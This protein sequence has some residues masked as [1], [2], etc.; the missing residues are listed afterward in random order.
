MSIVVNEDLELEQLDVKTAFLHGD[1]EEEIYMSQPEGYEVEGKEHWVCLLRKSLYGLKQ[2]PRQWNQKFDQFMKEIGFQRSCHDQCVYIK[3]TTDGKIYLLLYVDDM[4]VAC[5]DKK[6]IQA[7]KDQ[8]NSR[9]EMKDLGEARKILGIDIIRDRAHGT[10]KLSQADYMKKVLRA[11]NMESAKFVN[12]PIG[13][14]FKLKAA[15]EE[16]L[17][18]GEACDDSIPYCNAVGSLMYGMIGTRPDLAYAV[19]LVSR[20]M[21]NPLKEHW[22]A[23]K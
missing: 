13:S 17:K 14:H 12:T 8:L 20:F 21:S 22:E 1:L 10:L 4:L 6:Q 5:K 2:S 9:F 7:L 16:D 19:G 23:V 11:Y 3:Y 18:A 15:T